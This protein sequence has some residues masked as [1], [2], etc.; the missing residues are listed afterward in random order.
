MLA[1]QTV[2]YLG[3]GTGPPQI[4]P[5]MALPIPWRIFP[6]AFAIPLPCS[7]RTCWLESCVV[8]QGP[9]IVPDGELDTL[10]GA[11]GPPQIAPSVPATFA[12]LFEFPPGAA[13]S[14]EQTIMIPTRTI[15]TLLTP[16]AFMTSSRPSQT[17]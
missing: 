16:L 8:L 15:T 4:A 1:L 14:A 9:E 5:S 17:P 2:A 10:G 3:G 13:N 7:D 6:K 12:H 11:P